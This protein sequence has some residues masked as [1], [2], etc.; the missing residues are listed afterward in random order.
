MS[1]FTCRSPGAVLTRSLEWR[2]QCQFAP[3]VISLS[4]TPVSF[5]SKI[6]VMSLAQMQDARSPSQRR[7]WLA[8][9]VSSVRRYLGD[10][11]RIKRATKATPFV[12]IHPNLCFI[13]HHYL[14][15]R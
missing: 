2:H 15:P 1:Y 6:R 13:P 11:I 7:T 9:L 3:A 14:Y 4:H 10:T 5:E 12:G 8:R